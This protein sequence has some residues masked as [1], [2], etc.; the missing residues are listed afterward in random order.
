VRA[1]SELTQ[2]A[3][4]AHAAPLDLPALQAGLA[5]LHSLLAI[6]DLDAA[7][8]YEQVAPMLMCHLPAHAK[9]LGAAIEHYDFALA[10]K[11][12]DA[13]LASEDLRALQRAAS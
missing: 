13:L 9:A 5:Q 1:T 2:D 11:A 10:T 3:P 6:D 12:L 7:D 4:A 8:V